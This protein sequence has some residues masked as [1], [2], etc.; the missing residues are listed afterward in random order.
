M[1][2][3]KNIKQNKE[4]INQIQKF[5]EL[6]FPEDEQVPFFHLK[7]Q[8]ETSISDILDIYFPTSL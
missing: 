6:S 2:E 1:L 5:Y 4:I 3:F 8:A 7:N